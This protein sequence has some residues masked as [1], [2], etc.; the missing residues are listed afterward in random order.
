MAP[1]FDSARK[2]LLLSFLFAGCGGGGGGT[3]SL[4]NALQDLDLDPSGRTTVLSF[5][6][7]VAGL[8][9]GHLDSDGGQLAQS[10]SVNGSEATVVWDARVTPTHQVRIV[11]FG[12]TPDGFVAVDTSDD[13]VPVFS[14]TSGAMV[15]GLGGDTIQVQFNGPRVA[16]ELAEDP[17]NWSLR[18]GGTDM[19]LSGSVF[20]LTESTQTLTATLGTQANL[21][22]AF[23]LAA[24]S[25]MSVADVPLSAT[26]QAGAATG[27]SAQ[28]SL[29]TVVQNLAEDE[30]GHVVDFTFDEAMDP[31]F[32][33]ALSLFDAG[34]FP[35]IASSVQQVSGTLLRVTFTEPMIPGV[36]TVDV[37]TN[38]V[39]VHG[40]MIA[41]PGVKAIAQGA[42]V[43]NGFDGSPA[44]TTVENAGGDN[45]SVTFLQA[46]DPA[47]AEDDTH[48]ELDVDGG[49]IDLSLQTLAYDVASKTLT[50]TLA[51]DHPNGVSF[52]F[53]V[54]TGNEPIDVDGDLFTGNFSGT[55]S[56]D[57]VL[58]SVTSVTQ[59]RDIDPTGATLDVLFS[60]DVEQ[61]S[62]ETLVNYAVTGGLTV[63][64]ASQQNGQLV[65]LGLDGLAV[66]GDVTLDA[67]GVDDLAGN[68]MTAQTSITLSTSDADAPLGSFVLLAAEEGADN[69]RLQVQFDDDMLQ[70][71]VETLAN[72]SVESPLGTARDTLLSSIS[73]DTNSL[74][75]ELVFDGGDGINFQNGDDVQV[76]LSTMRDIGGNVVDATPLVGSVDGERT[77]PQLE[78]IWV[79]GA[80]AS[81]VHLQFSEPMQFL[82]DVFDVGTNP[83]GQTYYELLDGSLLQKG[84]VLS[85]TPDADLCGVEVVFSAGAIAGTDSL[86]VRGLAD[87]AGNSLA[88]LQ[89]VAIT[90][91]DAGDPRLDLGLSAA[92]TVSGED[93]DQLTVVFDR[94]IS[95]QG[96]ETAANY[97]LALGV[98]PVDL[99]NAE[100]AF[101]G[102]RTVTIDLNSMGSEPL[103]NASGYTL[104]VDNLRSVQGVAM[105]SASA[106]TVTP[107][108][109]L[110]APD[111][112]E[113]RTRLDAADAANS[114]LLE[115]DEAV[116]P[117]DLDNVANV[118]IGGGNPDSAEAIGARTGRATWALGV[119]A[120][121]VVNVNFDDLAGNASGLV[122]RA[123][124]AADT[125]GPSVVSV[126]GLIQEGVGGDLVSVQF[127]HPVDAVSALQISNYAVTQG[128]VPVD[129]DGA[130][131]RYH[132]APPT[133]F[134]VLPDGVDLD[135]TQGIQVV[136]DGVTNQGGLAI[137]PA[138]DVSGSVSGDSSAPTMALAFA[139]YRED[140]TGTAIEV[141]FSE[142]VEPSIVSQ[143]F[144]WSADGGQS[145]TAVDVL[146]PDRVLLTLTSPLSPGDEISITGVT[147]VAN[148]VAG[149]LSIAPT[150]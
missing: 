20:A 99:A 97:D 67:S 113:V 139:N 71:E 24:A 8:A 100:F 128:G 86:N 13:T 138:A 65:R 92:L 73:F 59:N 119:T 42:P 15:A 53:D 96:A 16:P 6:G 103:A 10:V 74:V 125:N 143:W 110:L 37:S 108:G 70:S 27:D 98:T 114:V 57:A 32:S 12:D 112:P 130:F 21:H 124:Q 3:A 81:H 131:L 102:D 90:A 5:S 123:I 149:T 144:L 141:V 142:D 31:V 11:G 122:S 17:A 34:G 69:D 46:I 91:E 129:L 66:P 54:A 39:D 62:A 35:V 150:L 58:P 126:Q 7:D 50:I 47:D 18:V 26:F 105:A 41:N 28:P 133:A 117:D 127:D 101:D 95:R 22:A 82:D 140:A 68:T 45:L 48:W 147:D 40:N 109:D 134:I 72:W 36:D 79:E 43:A 1:G 56:G 104:T 145:I 111:L 25:L 93:N 9:T 132:S 38:L 76:V 148:N 64:S 55:V 84:T 94:S 78:S 135:S 4:T 51:D 80:T 29:S 63:L 60:E 115:M 52:D 137:S 19:D 85:V 120:G 30:F 77:A 49:A 23:E 14:I 146:H 89:Q 121:Q 116:N 88:P 2:A 44:L 87:L 106:D 118:D 107:T 83:S 61:V 33:T 136:V 75:A